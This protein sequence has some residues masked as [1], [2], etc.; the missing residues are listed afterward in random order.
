MSAPE[1][2]RGQAGTQQACYPNEPYGKESEGQESGKEQEAPAVRNIDA[3]DGA[4]IAPQRRTHALPF[5]VGM[6]RRDGKVSQQ[7]QNEYGRRV[8]DCIH[9]PI[10]LRRVSH[11]AVRH[12]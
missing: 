6:Q 10:G 1:H 4:E 7:Y 9:L 2:S 11:Q 5:L 12:R 3:N 8:E